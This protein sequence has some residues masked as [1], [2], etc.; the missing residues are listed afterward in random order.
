MRTGLWISLALL[1]ATI[2]L[3]CWEEHET[4]RLSQQYI[5]AAEELRT[6]SEIADWNRASAVSTAYLDNWQRTVP[7]LQMLI[8]HEDIDD[9][10]LALGQLKAAIDAKDQSACFSA[11]AELKE[12]ARHIFHRDAFTLG[13][14]L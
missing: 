4:K 11:C 8:N 3:G 10:T 5:S 13:N 14:V 12:N 2:A 7:W 1:C 6:L 9:I